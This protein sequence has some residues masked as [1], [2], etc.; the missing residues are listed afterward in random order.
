MFFEDNKDFREQIKSGKLRIY[1]NPFYHNKVNVGI[2][3]G[4]PISAVLANLYLLE[5]DK[6]IIEKYC[7]KKKNGFLEVFR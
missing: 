6:K 1:K 7:F 2:P 5:F 4:L 3:Q